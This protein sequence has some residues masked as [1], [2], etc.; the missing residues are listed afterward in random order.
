VVASTPLAL[1]IVANAVSVA[2]PGIAWAL[3]FLLAWRAPGFAESLGL[4]RREFWLLLP[5]ALATSFAVLPLM[6]VAQDVLAV[7]FSGAVFPLLVAT[8]ALRRLFP[9][10]FR[11]TTLV[12]V[13]LGL[14]SAVLLGLVLGAATPGFDAF[15][16]ALA[17]GRTGA[18]DVLVGLVALVFGAGAVA[19]FGR[20]GHVGRARAL[21]VFLASSAVM[22]L[23][24]FGTEAIAGVGIVESFPYFLVPPVFAGIVLGVNA[25]VLFP[26]EEGY[27]LPAAFFAGSWGTTLGADLLR[28]PGLYGP[29]PAGLY[30]IGGAGVSDL[31]YLSGFL[32]LGGAVLVHVLLGRPFP[33]LGV[34]AAPTLPNP[35]ARLRAAY[36]LGL[37]GETAASLR[38]SAEAADAA[39]AEARLLKLG[40][41]TNLDDPRPWQGLTVPGW[42][43]SDHANLR[44]AAAANTTEP[45]ESLRGWLTA[46]WLVRWSAM[47]AR[48]RFAPIGLRIVAYLVDLVVVLLVATGVLVGA[49]ALVPGSLDTL[50]SSVGYN[51]AIYACLTGGFLYFVLAE[52]WTGTTLGKRL[53]RLEV[54]SR[55]LGPLD[56]VGALVRNVSLVPSLTVAVVGIGIAVAFLARGLG[57]IS[58]AGVGLPAGVVAAIGVGA[59][60]GGG[61]AVFGGV[62]VLAITLS[63]ERQRV[64]DAWAR[65]WVVRSVSAPAVP[66]ALA[67]TASARSG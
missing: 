33:S 25:R 53:F 34:P 58:V 29:G 6:P 17:I 12:L 44:S 52:L 20:S 22:V 39:A 18:I 66:L 37:H 9:A 61:V 49:A 48:E 8:L 64:G 56:G 45:V 10:N 55:S 14:E 3:F 36:D 43:V 30:V 65:T 41:V 19:S 26:G 51:A 47:L 23:T 21:T 40:T 46:R 4:G 32:A 62:G 63:F 16:R 50:L 59:F 24:F 67:S 11:G 2:L 5:G 7:S 15:A 60:V 35:A 27:A 13:A 31:V 38:A 1:D 57:A 28:Q 42:V 54:R